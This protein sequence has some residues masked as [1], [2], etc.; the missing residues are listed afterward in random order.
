M[1]YPFGETVILHT[2]TPTTDARGNE[3]MS[4]TDQT[5]AGCPVWPRMASE[6][7]YG[8]DTRITG[9][10]IVV[11]PEF[12]VTALDEVTVRGVRYQCDGEPGLYVNPFTGTNAGYQVA[13]TKITG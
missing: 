13:L 4:W 8:Q 3:V 2:G 1:H 9:L 6:I 12:P 10:W 7:T 5:V 11:P